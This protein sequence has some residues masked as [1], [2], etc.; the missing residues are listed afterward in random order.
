MGGSAVLRSLTRAPPRKPSLVRPR[1][2]RGDHLRRARLSALS[3]VVKS[4]VAAQVAL[5]PTM[6]G[7]AV[8]LA[9]CAHARDVAGSN[10]TRRP[11]PSAAGGVEFVDE[12]SLYVLESGHRSGQNRARTRFASHAL[13]RNGTSQSP[14]SLSPSRRDVFGALYIC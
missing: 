4:V 10:C 5:G 3:L 2:R 13:V 14:A 8:P 6:R 7:V 1:Y 11:A 12:R 9:V